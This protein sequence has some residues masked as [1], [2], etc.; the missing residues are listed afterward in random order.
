L[1]GAT[2]AVLRRRLRDRP[3]ELAFFPEQEPYRVRNP[4]IPG[5]PHRL[6]LKFVAES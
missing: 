5:V 2:P 6:S 1:S 4:R 3:P